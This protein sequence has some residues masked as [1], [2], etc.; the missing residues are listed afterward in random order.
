MNPALRHFYTNERNHQILIALLKAHGIRNV[1]ASPG[2][3][4]SVFV[5]SIQNDPFFRI[6]SAVDERGAAYIACG[7]ALETGEPVVVSCTGATAARNYMSGATEAY[8]AKLP[9]L[10]LTS[11]QPDSRIGHL[12]PQVTDRTR[13]PPDVCK[14]SLALPAVQT[15]DDEWACEVVA[16]R[17]LLELRRHGG[18]PVH[19]NLITAYRYSGKTALACRDLPP[20]RVIRRI[21][22]DR[23]MPGMPKGKIGV[24]VGSHKPFSE[25][26]TRI[27]DAF[28]EANGAVVFTDHTGN[29]NG[30]F[31]VPFAL[32]INQAP[33]NKANRPAYEVDLLIHV[34]EV[35]GEE[36][37]PRMIKS[38]ETWRVSEDGELRDTFRNLTHVFEMPEEAF[39]RHYAG[40]PG[41]GPSFLAEC[42][43]GYASLKARLAEKLDRMPFSNAWIAQRTAPALPGNATVVLSILNTLRTWNYAE[44]KDSVRVFCPVGGFGI[45]GATSLA[46]GASL[47]D[48]RRPCCCITG[49]LAFF[50]DLNAL[51]NRHVGKNLRVLLVNNGLG[52]EFRKSYAMAYNLLGDEVAE[53]VAAQGHFGRQSPALVRHYAEDLGFTYLAARNKDEFDAALPE[54]ASDRL[55]KPVLLEAFVSPDDEAD[56]L[57]I[58]HDRKPPQADGQEREPS[59]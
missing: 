47:A 5:G 28:C 32:A 55:E 48:S 49:D 53:Y 25:G 42:R 50:Y 39:F 1:V 22:R 15:A 56:A 33:L 11:S 51:G 54:F 31:K 46:L 30:R 20:A 19:L 4:N 8:Y 7:L 24:F 14:I 58:V 21:E 59:R 9:L 36:G 27:V 6:V 10:I 16:N 57:D 3:A 13:P 44:F 29:Y 45:D 12:V 23:T 17:A 26:Q 40:N 18:G 34:G 41:G 35:S 52:V 38:G 37:A 2:T 43:A